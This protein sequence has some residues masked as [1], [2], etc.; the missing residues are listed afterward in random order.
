MK[1]TQT[2]LDLLLQRYSESY[3]DVQTVR[4][5]LKVAT[6]IRDELLKDDAASKKAD[7]TACRRQGRTGENGQSGAGA[8]A[9]RYRQPHPA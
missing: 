2:R 1:N 7:Q 4:G 8:R 5:Q 6:Q 9:A 3:P